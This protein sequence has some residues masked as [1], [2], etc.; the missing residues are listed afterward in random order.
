MNGN[1]H[2]AL[3]ACCHQKRKEQYTKSALNEGWDVHTVSRGTDA[4]DL[5]HKR[6][7]DLIVMDE[8]ID[9]Q[10]PVEFSLSA[11]DIATNHPA[12]VVAAKRFTPVKA[13]WDECRVIHAA[14]FEDIAAKLPDL[15]EQ[16]AASS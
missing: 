4:F 3:I 13:L 2:I 14:P 16:V 1:A 12:I 8:S 9:D 5:L 7:Y 15:L 6:R 10:S 11:A